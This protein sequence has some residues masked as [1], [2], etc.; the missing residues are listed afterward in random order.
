MVR[1]AAILEIEI[2]RLGGE[3]RRCLLAGELDALG[4][5][6]IGDRGG[7]DGADRTVGEL[8]ARADDVLGIYLRSGEVLAKAATV[9][10][11]PARLWNRSRVWIA[12]VMSTPPPSRAFM[13]RPG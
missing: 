5:A 7:I 2:E 11:G 8:D 10:I 6:G 1:V 9:V 13:P 12:W 4:E 3:H